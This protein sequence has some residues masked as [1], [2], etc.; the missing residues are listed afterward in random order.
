MHLF[1]AQSLNSM[2]DETKYVDAVIK[3]YDKNNFVIHSKDLKDLSIQDSLEKYI[4][5]QEEPFGDPSIIAHGSLMEMSANAGIKV[6]LNGQG[7]DELFFG[8]NNMAQAILSRQFRSAEFNHFRQNI[9]GLNLG[10]NYLFRTLLKSIFPQAEFNLRTR[11]RLKRRNIIRSEFS[12]NVDN[13]LISLFKY[14]NIHDVWRESIYGVH[15]PHLVH[16]DDRN[17][18][19]YSIEG[20]MPFLDHRIAEFVARVKPEEFLKNGMRKYIL[21]EACKQYLPE[22]VYERKDKIGFYTP[23]INILG[24]DEKWVTDQLNHNHLFT[25]EHINKLLKKLKTKSL[26][27]NDALQ[28]WR[29]ISLNVWMKKYNIESIS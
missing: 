5:I 28:I 17:A 6:I 27:T 22:I 25:D 4:T 24:N 11:S 2:Y 21:R 20:R 9:A 1:T 23:L 8:Y 16:Y 7:A 19:A 3:K 13:T 12:E 14:N 15:I 26:E 29:S 18:M 10:S